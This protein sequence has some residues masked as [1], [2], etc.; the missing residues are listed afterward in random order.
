MPKTQPLCTDA[1]LNLRDRVLV[2]VEEN[3]FIAFPGKEGTQGAPALKNNVF[4]PWENLVRSFIEIF[5][6]QDC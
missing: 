6:R 2:K 1:K 4:Q 5:Q 3:R